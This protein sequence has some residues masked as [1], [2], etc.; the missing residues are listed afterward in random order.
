MADLDQLSIQITSD[1]KKAEDAIESLVRGLENLNTALGNLDVNK[2]KQFTNAVSKLSNIGNSGLGGV[3]DVFREIS[4]IQMPDMNGV[5]DAIR[6]A[7]KAGIDLSKVPPKA[8]EV[9]R[10]LGEIS[11][12]SQK[13]TSS[14]NELGNALMVISNNTQLSPQ[15]STALT[16][17]E[18][19]LPAIRE[20][21][22]FQPPDL[23]TMLE[24]M[25][26]FVEYI[27]KALSGMRAI[28]DKR[29]GLPDKYYDPIDTTGEWV[30]KN[31][32][33]L[34]TAI[35]K[36]TQM[37]KAA[38]GARRAT[39]R[40]ADSMKYITGPDPNVFDSYGSWVE[41][42]EEDVKQ[43]ENA[44][45]DYGNAAQEA[46]RKAEGVAEK[47]KGIASRD[48]LAN[49]VVLGHTLEDISGKFNA[50]SDKGIQIFKMLTTPL[51]W[52]SNEYVEKFHG[53]Q[54]TIENFQ[55]NF[56]AHMKKMSDFWKRTMRT[57]TFMIVRKA[58]DAVVKEV[59]TAIQS[60]AM[61]SNAMGTA[62]NTDISNMVADFQ[63][64]GKSIVSVF[65]PLLNYIAPIIDA[66]VD[67]IALLISYIGMLFAALGGGSTFTKAKKNVGNY[68]ES[69]DQASKSAKN[70]TMGIDE[71]N[72]LSENGGSGSAK[73]YDGWEDAW[74]EVDIPKW[75]QD[76]A[77]WLKDLWHKFFDPIKEAWDRAKQYIIDGFKTMLNSLEQ[78][79]S[80]IGA[81]FLEMWNQ[82]KTI[83]MFE[84][85]FRI[86][87]DIERVIRNLANGLD[88]AWNYNKTGLKIL[89]NIRDI[90]A[91][92]VDHARNLSYYMIGW[93]DNIDFRPLFQSFEKLTDSAKRLADFLGGVIEDIFVYGI[94]KYIQWMI[95]DGIPH[96]QTTIAEVLDSFN[97]VTLRERLRPLIEA[98][99]EML[100]N[101]HTGVTNAIG[102]L[103]RA[104]AEFVNSGEFADFL[105]NLANISREITAAR[106]EKVLTGLGKGILE[107]GK[108]VVKFVNSKTFQKFIKAIGEW[109][110]KKST[111]EIAKTLTNIANAILLFKFGA[112]ATAK[113]AGVFKFFSVITA[114]K[115]LTSIAHELTGVATA[116]EAL[117]STAPA[118]G[119]LYNPF[120]RLSGILPSLTS[121][122]GTTVGAF[123]NMFSVM[124]VGG[125]IKGIFEAGTT[126]INGFAASL[127]PL[128][129]LIGSVATAFLEW[130]S[131]GKSASDLAHALNGDTDYS[132]G[133]SLL[134]IIGKIGLASAAFTAFLGF[135]AGLVAGLVVGAIS[136]IKGIQDAVEQINFD[137]IG[138]AITTQGEMTLSEV[139]S[140]YGQATDIINENINKWKDAERNLTQDRGDIT[141]YAKEIQN[142]SSVFENASGVTASMAD[143]LVGKYEDL[144]GSIDN[145][146]DQSTDALVSN[147]LAQKSFLEAQGVDV[148]QMIVNIY[149]GA[150]EEKKAIDGAVETVKEAVKGLDGLTE[151]TAAYEEQMK[152]VVE[153]TSQANT[154][155]G[156]YTN[157]FSEIDTSEAV[158][159]IE[160]L[161]HSLD[162]S[163]YADDPDAAL[164][165]IS[166]SIDEVKATYTTKMS[167][168]KSEADRLK[169][170]A[171]LMPNITDEQLAAFNL[172]IDYSYQQ[173]GEKLA[174]AS[175]QVLG[176]YSQDLSTQMATVAQ[177]AADDW[178]KGIVSTFLQPYQNK[179]EY[180]LY[181]MQQYN[182][183][184]VK[185]GVEESLKSAYAKIPNNVSEDVVTS[186]QGI[187]D[188]QTQAFYDASMMGTGI[189]QDDNYNMLTNVLGAVDK[190]DY[191]TP[192]STFATQHYNAMYQHMQGYDYNSLGQ[193]WNTEAGGAVLSNAQLF[194]DSNRLTANEGA[195]AFSQEYRD[196]LSQNQ[197]T[198]TA[199]EETGATYGGSI[200]E[201]LNKKIEEDQETTKPVLDT[202][203]SNIKTWIHDNPFMPFG[204]PN[205]KTQEYGKDT[206]TGF[207]MGITTNA[208]TSIAAVNTW[209]SYI[210]TAIRTK[211]EEVRLTFTTMLS[212]IFSGEGWDYN[213]PIVTL[214][215]NVATAI[216]TN[217]V[218]LGE[219]ILGTTLPMFFETYLTPFFANENWQ[220]L[221]DLLHEETFVPNFENFRVWFM[222][223][224]MTPWW[225]NDL[226]FW[227]DKV[228]WDDEIFTPLKDNIQKH[229]NNFLTWW[230]KSM[231][232]WWNND[233]IPW[234][235]KGKWQEQ[236][237]HIKEVAE[238]VFEAI[239][240]YIQEKIESARDSVTSACEEMSESISEVISLIDE[241]IEKMTSLGSLNIGIGVGGYASGGFP[242]QG[243]LFLANE[244]GPE[245]IGTIGG[246]TA[247]AS[248]D[249]IT[250]IADAVYATGN[251]ESVLLSQLIGLTRQMLDKDPVIIGDKDI[252]RM[253]NNGQ[254]QLGMT[255]IT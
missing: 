54:E 219:T 17:F 22:S 131:V 198:I 182:D 178:D 243:S 13:A 251:Q 59:G 183:N 120:T 87:G 107:V 79:L 174:A 111:D 89:E 201:G 98:V 16:V 204:S 155:L 26:E 218:V 74:E 214:F 248:N 129:V 60:L 95:E 160:A 213:T 227:F 212:S 88:E 44:V 193:L 125:G 150:E 108:A 94:L 57:F 191:E 112:F 142:F 210:N 6:E 118:V 71:L 244:A 145:Y 82:E 169:E 92:L 229:W 242:T 110:D 97:F 35:D 140:W 173:A 187:I 221:F 135:P 68:A 76:L 128:T 121:N 63:Y 194:E 199:L 232:A 119:A 225:E 144:K 69:L 249:E 65:A 133:G 197:E 186:M 151:G 237:D 167:E 172:S 222:E 164:K 134:G 55:K 238:E 85:L 175:N 45:N 99:E 252:A 176:L 216:N 240:A 10:S 80:D 148:D 207:N 205:K 105:T 33:D 56:N 49:F 18:K 147:L 200:V 106:V 245:L 50:L 29:P 217:I 1:S 114:L 139:K 149:K 137:R 122:I 84:Q 2:I 46:G 34:Y 143:K 215:T 27:Y 233:V 177:N 206:V 136:A 67:R 235:E 166:S 91:I 247:V 124:G 126:A 64:L 37:A 123:Q 253:A 190:L 78:L 203:F 209:F 138:D 116:T 109:I 246:R 223:E 236:F 254:N 58:I 157:Q 156:D 23:S 28:E 72:I 104:L 31:P 141:E 202:W 180:I 4:K 40:L 146:I 230:R 192:A 61:Y 132:I 250:G 208:S 75:V 41:D 195:A 220:P 154:A 77:D 73:P 93:A 9:S 103:G 165:A 226:L 159:E 153:A 255:I 185:N 184:L 211:L 66:I 152:K 231:N 163:Q 21:S 170:E 70:L 25:E 32:P 101:I 43:A 86:I 96:L 8:E 38:D 12:S 158:S 181:Q 115:N 188:E 19:M 239:R 52:A 196:F 168:L 53:M 117:G 102:N 42:V 24:Q 83:R 20:L 171:K 30:E 224:A 3:A 47:T 130:K 179:E 113:L 15:G 39:A 127:S 11:N 100:Q 81:D 51:K 162:L 5:A 241:L 36:Y 90:F 62:F 228:K 48:V 161:G 234:F 14:V 189:M 7:S